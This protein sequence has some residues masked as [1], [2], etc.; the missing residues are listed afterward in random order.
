M[1]ILIVYDGSE[2]ADAAIVD[3]RRAGLPEIAE[4]VVL[5]VAETAIPAVSESFVGAG[6][7]LGVSF[8]NSIE[9]MTRDP[10]KE[11]LA[12]AAQAA[13]RLAADF[14]KWRIGTESCIDAA[15]AAIIRKI[16]AWQPD[17]VVTGSHGRVGVGRLVL[18]SISQQVLHHADCSVRIGRH[19]IH[20]QLRPIRLLIGIDG[21][22]S[23]M[24]ALAMVKRRNWPQGTEI[25]VVAVMDSRSLF[26]CPFV[27]TPEAIPMELEVK[28]Q[29][30]L[31]AKIEP[32][33]QDLRNSGM[34]AEAEVH[35]GN[36]GTRL[37]ALAE[38]WAADCV[39]VGARGLSTLK[40][41]LLGSVSTAV[42]LHACCSVEVVRLSSA[43][44]TPLTNR[45]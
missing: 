37:I 9:N 20:S 18:G 14:P 8:P 2:C 16:H 11:A 3:L 23:A 5:A 19:H 24:A 12:F 35:C 22:D 42:A 31:T 21:S 27:A 17:L 41:L 44:N 15:G 6:A 40:R 7:A 30:E 39:F 26:A 4:A 28:W 33:V 36:P 13:N 10:L 45:E 1:K 34:L 43:H 32:L 29:E 25:R 38:E